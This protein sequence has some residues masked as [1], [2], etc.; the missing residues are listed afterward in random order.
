MA[1]ETSTTPSFASCETPDSVFAE[2]ELKLPDGEGFRSLPPQVSLAKM[3]QR[4]RQ[5]RE[6]FPAGLRCPEERWQAK[7]TVEFQL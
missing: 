4:I 2:L 3:I 7:T 6:W 5:L 1:A